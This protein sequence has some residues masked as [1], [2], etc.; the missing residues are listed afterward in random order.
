ML[1][2][3]KKKEKVREFIKSFFETAWGEVVP[4]CFRLHFVSEI[5]PEVQLHANL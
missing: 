4:C 2:R 1:A 3:E 5:F